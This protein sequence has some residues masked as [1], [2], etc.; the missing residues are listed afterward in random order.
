VSYSDQILGAA[1]FDLHGL[2]KDY[3]ISA[4]SADISWIQSI[5]QALGLQ[6]L[7][8]AS[9][10]LNDFRHAVIHGAT[11]HAIVIRQANCY[12][13]LLVRQNDALIS[14]DFLQWALHFNPVLLVDDPRFSAT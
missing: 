5:F 4:E 2:P 12:V 8:T 14:E 13:A 9:F 3:Y 11:F 1:I 7:L 6:A 10:Q